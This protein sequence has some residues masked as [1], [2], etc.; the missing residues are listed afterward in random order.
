MQAAWPKPVIFLLALPVPFCTSSIR[1]VSTLEQ[2]ILDLAGRGCQGTVK[3]FTSW[4]AFL[5]GA[6][7]PVEVE[8]ALDA[9]VASGKL[10]Q[11]QDIPL[12]F[13]STSDL[14]FPIRVEY[15]VSGEVTAG[16]I[17]MV[18]SCM[19]AFLRFHGA[20]EENVMD[21][22]IATTEAME[23]AVK[24]SDHSPIRVSYWIENRVFH[25]TI[26]NRLSDVRLEQDIAD[27]KYTSTTTLMRGMMV[28]VKLFDEMDIQIREDEK[29][30][31][32]AAHKA[33]LPKV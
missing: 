14:T 13:H 25:I 4:A 32:F 30:A 15:S 28:M 21:I 6:A 12:E 19:E 9:C 23:N 26:T 10:R 16:P 18:R 27:G 1:L 11:H 29:I 5:T 24:Y 31:V 20:S 2:T 33:L 22:S 3:D 17:Q 8:R 7:D